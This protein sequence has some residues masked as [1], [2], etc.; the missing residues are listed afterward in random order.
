MAKVL[1]FDIYGTLINTHGVVTLLQDYIGDEAQ[2]FSNV[3]R[4]KQ[5]EYSF[6]R[7]LMRDYQPFSV[8]TQQALDYADQLLGTRLSSDQKSSLLAEYKVLPAFDDVTESLSALKSAGHKM[9]AFSNGTA[10]AVEELLQH[11]G[12]RDLFDGVVSVDTLKTFKPNLEVYAHMVNIGGASTEST[13]LIS[14]NPFDVIGA[15][16]A[17][18]QA[19]WIQRSS[20]AVLDPWEVEPTQTVNSL[21][22]LVAVID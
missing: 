8:C 3:W 14:S 9:Y 17:G 2:T 13:W 18:L 22:D 21:N 20:A 11:A 10:E 1:A 6:R 5:L 12:I 4:D 15:R 16:T 19:A 7:G